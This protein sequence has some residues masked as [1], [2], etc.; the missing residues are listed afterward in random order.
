MK[1][2][3]KII[4]LPDPEVSWSNYKPRLASPESKT[5]PLLHTVSAVLGIRSKSAGPWNKATGAMAG[6]KHLGT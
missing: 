5:R 3:E 2:Y 6:R 1:L 4:A